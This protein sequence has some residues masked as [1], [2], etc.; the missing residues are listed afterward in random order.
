MCVCVKSCM[1]QLQWRRHHGFSQQWTARTYS[2]AISETREKWQRSQRTSKYPNYF[3]PF[4]Y[5]SFLA[6]NQSLN[7]YSDFMC[8][9]VSILYFEPKSSSTKSIDF[10]FNKHKIYLVFHHNK[11]QGLHLISAFCSSTSNL[12]RTNDAA[13]G[14]RTESG[15]TLFALTP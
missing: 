1:L 7:I 13:N 6:S 11:F 9:L 10:I 12:S 8:I 2:S 3:L 15:Q 4:L 5:S 14:N